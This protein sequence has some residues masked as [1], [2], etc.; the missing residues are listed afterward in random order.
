MG[1]THFFRP[2][3]PFKIIRGLGSPHDYKSPHLV[4]GT[5]DEKTTLCSGISFPKVTK[6]KSLVTCRGC[7]RAMKHRK[8]H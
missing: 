1:K 4:T 5:L 7:Q 2:A 3:V 6:D 8:N